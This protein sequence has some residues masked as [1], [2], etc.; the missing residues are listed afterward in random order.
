[1]QEQDYVLKRL[2]E[3]YFGLIRE[4]YTQEV[5]DELQTRISQRVGRETLKFLIDRG[6]LGSFSA[7]NVHESLEGYFSK[8]IEMLEHLS[9]SLVDK[10][11]QE[12]RS[13]FSKDVESSHGY[14][15][16]MIQEVRKKSDEKF[17]EELT[18]QDIKE[19]Y[20]K[21]G[22]GVSGI[23]KITQRMLYLQKIIALKD[24][25]PGPNRR[26]YSEFLDAVI[27]EAPYLCQIFFGE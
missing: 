4:R 22:E 2:D 13:T 21:V 27:E 15:R 10:I 16:A 26:Y 12:M 14:F 19:I 23:T 17:P 3:W 18:N 9:P 5:V 7:E 8:N 25:A 20:L 11:P 24:E 6:M 1:M